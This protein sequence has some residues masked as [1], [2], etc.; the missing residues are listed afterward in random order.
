MLSFNRGV[1]DNPGPER[2][3][4]VQRVIDADVAW[5]DDH[6]PLF[7]FFWGRPNKA[8]LTD[9]AQLDSWSKEEDERERAAAKNGGEYYPLTAWQK[10][11]QE[12]ETL[13]VNNGHLMADLHASGRALP[14]EPVRAPSLR[15]VAVSTLDAKAPQV[16]RVLRGVRRRVKARKS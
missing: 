15:W 4:L 10:L 5:T 16:S 13:R 9:R 7:A 3:A 11:T 6:E 2:D 14:G 8:V 12:R 1:H